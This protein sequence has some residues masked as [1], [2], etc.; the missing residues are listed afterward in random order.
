MASIL[1][2]LLIDLCAA[3]HAR[4]PLVTSSH[5][6]IVRPHVRHMLFSIQGISMQASPDPDEQDVAAREAVGL[7]PRRSE[8]DD[9]DPEGVP[10]WIRKIDAKL[11]PDGIFVARGAGAA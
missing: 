8:P 3:F 2:W 9:P 4:P 7:S 11:D 5:G 1:L 10:D 6:H